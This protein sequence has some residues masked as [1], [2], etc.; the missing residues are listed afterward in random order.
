MLEIE[1]L[2]DAIHQLFFRASETGKITLAD[3]YG[4]LAVLLKANIS[5]EE[6]RLIDRLFYAL[7]RDRIQLVDDLSALENY[8]LGT[9]R[10]M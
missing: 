4:L 6:Y 1:P 9:S 10:S 8:S 3:R 2:P 7:R 5:E